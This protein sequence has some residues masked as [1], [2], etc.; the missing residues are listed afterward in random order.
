MCTL[1]KNVGKEEQYGE[2]T[3]S[4]LNLVVSKTAVKLKVAR[5]P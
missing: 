3:L 2:L 4:S 5:Q 1:V